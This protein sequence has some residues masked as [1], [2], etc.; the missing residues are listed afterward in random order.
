MIGMICTCFV[1]WDLYDLH[2]LFNVYGTYMY[3]LQFQVDLVH[4]IYI[5]IAA[6]RDIEV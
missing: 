3:D 2:H 5:S 6:E 4:N 1:G